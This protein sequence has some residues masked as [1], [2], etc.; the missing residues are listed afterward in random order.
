LPE[1]ERERERLLQRKNCLRERGFYRNRFTLA[2]E[3]GRG[4]YK[5]RLTRGREAFEKGSLT[6]EGRV[7]HEETYLRESGCYK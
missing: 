6:L 2:T 5:E 1:I 3:R 7:F 4:C